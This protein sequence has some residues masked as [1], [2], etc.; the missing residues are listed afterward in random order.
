MDNNIPQKTVSGK[1]HKHLAYF[2]T[3]SMFP[4]LRNLSILCKVWKVPQSAG[5]YGKESHDIL[6]WHCRVSF[7]ALSSAL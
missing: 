5:K 1:S 3:L 4:G 2:V 7:P 6:A